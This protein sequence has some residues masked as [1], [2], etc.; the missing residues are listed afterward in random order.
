MAHKILQKLVPADA[1][2][3]KETKAKLDLFLKLCVNQEKNK[4]V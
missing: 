2:V 1:D 3:L 4:V